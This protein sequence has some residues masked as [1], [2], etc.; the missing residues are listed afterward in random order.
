MQFVTEQAPGKLNLALDV[1]SKRPDGYH[2]MRMLMQTVRLCDTVTLRLTPSG[3]W[4]LTCCDEAGQPGR[5]PQGPENLA[6]RAAE[7]FCRAIGHFP[8][9]LSIEITK[10]IP[11]QAGMAGGSADAAAVLR[12]LNRLYDS[13]LSQDKLLDLAAQLGSDVPYCVLGGTMLAEGRGEILTPWPQL[14]SCGFVLCKPALSCPTGALFA[15]LDEMQRAAATRADAAA[16]DETAARSAAAAAQAGLAAPAGA[17]QA[18]RRPDFAA[19]RG[20]LERGD[21]AALGR[22]L[23][24]VFGPVLAQRHPEVL[25]LQ[26]ALLATGALGA[27]LTGTGSVVFGLYPTF[28]AARAAADSLRGNDASIFVAGPV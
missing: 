3:P 9:G 24:N 6:Y 14:P 7:L 15:A 2:E 25:A 4:Q 28:D 27:Q 12:G 17:A 21:L 19:L 11:M 1:L 8:E 10:R 26:K 22:G 20:A 18:V 13:R 5:L 16:A 23:C